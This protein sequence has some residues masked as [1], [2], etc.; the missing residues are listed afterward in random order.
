M[1]ISK[2]LSVTSNE[3]FKTIH[4]MANQI[5]IFIKTLRTITCYID[6]YCQ[7]R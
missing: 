4:T 1:L 3:L 7:M 2:R 6:G 5:N